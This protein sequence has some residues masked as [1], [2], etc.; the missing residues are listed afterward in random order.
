M[1]SLA[2]QPY[3][4][5][6]LCYSGGSYRT[7]GDSLQP[8]SLLFWATKILGCTLLPKHR[9]YLLSAGG[10]PKDS[11]D[12]CVQLQV[13]T[14]RVRHSPLHHAQEWLLWPINNKLKDKSYDLPVS[15]AQP[16]RH[17]WN[18]NSITKWKL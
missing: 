5:L 3:A 14:V 8:S 1:S 12:R 7:S 15:P 9:A 13:Q 16:N 11:S 4:Q 18:K 6:K 2:V 10:G 17:W